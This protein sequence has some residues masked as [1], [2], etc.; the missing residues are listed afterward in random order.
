MYYGLGGLDQKV[1]KY[2]DFDGGV[3]FEAGANNGVDQSNTLY[4][5]ESR[6]WRGILVEPTPRRF[7]ECVR[8][9]PLARVE[10]G[11]L[12]PRDYESTRVDMIYCNLM[13]VTK[14]GR[15]SPE[16]DLDYV[17]A[18]LPF[19]RRDEKVVEYKAKA[20]TIDAVL[21]KHGVTHI[22]FMSLDVEGFE[23]EALRGADFDRVRPTWLMVEETIDPAA[24]KQL[25]EPWYEEVDLLSAHDYLFRARS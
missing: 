14:G 21:Q 15:G 19:L 10:W 2:I 11:A 23:R 8:N 20:W 16:A 13:T 1:E 25:L 22:D 5:E 4:F 24:L 3:F 9:R 18:G 12:V 7:L 6:G 17:R